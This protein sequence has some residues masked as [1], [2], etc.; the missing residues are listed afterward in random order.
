MTEKEGKAEREVASYLEGFFELIGENPG[1]EVEAKSPD[2][3]YVNIQGKSDFFSE[4]R[5]KL[6]KS[7]SV[8]VKVLLERQYDLDKDVQIDI[9]GVKLS[10]RKSLERFAL[11]AAERAVSKG[12]KV[13]LNP[14]PPVERKWIH[15]ALSDSEDVETY[16]VGEGD[17]RRVI[18]KP[19]EE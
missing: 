16:S 17:D 1:L 13:R 4:E 5:E 10:R 2:E 19:K 12:K 9:N 18:I 15:V 8:L 14:M 11:N 6:A 7:L 3:L